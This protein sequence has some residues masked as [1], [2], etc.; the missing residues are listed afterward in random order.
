MVSVLS[1]TGGALAAAPV[2]VAL[3]PLVVHSQDR[4]E[5]LQAGM[6][7]MLLSRLARS[8]RLA[9]IR[10]ADEKA[11]TTDLERARNA[12]R[13]VGARFVVFGSFTS[14]GDGASLDLQCARTDENDPG[15]RQI[16]VQAGALGAIIPKL[17]DLADRVALYIADPA[18]AT[19]A[20]AAS[21]PGTVPAP[22]AS[23]RGASQDEIDELRRRVEALEA[24][25]RAS[26]ASGLPVPGGAPKPAAGSRIDS[27]PR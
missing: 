19:A 11:A 2:K 23:R 6:G 21:G 24:N 9:V 26:S 1:G 14:F 20:V 17:D 25:A 13:A 27:A 7:D 12:G 5:Y 18:S 8:N 16:F 15:A 10:V 22:A 4:T 3:L